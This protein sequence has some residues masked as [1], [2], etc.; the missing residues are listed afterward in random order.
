MANPILSNGQGSPQSLY[1]EYKVTLAGGNQN[2]AEGHH[3]VGTR[4]YLDDG[5]V[6]YYASNGAAA[7]TAGELVSVPATT[8]L[9]VVAS[10]NDIILT[11]TVAAAPW[12]IG[13]TR[14]ALYEADI[15]TA[16]IITNRYKD[17]YLYMEDGTG[18]GFCYKIRGHTQFTYDG[19]A[20]TG[21]IDLYDPIKVAPAATSA[22]SFAVNPYDR[23]VVSAAATYP[24]GVSPTTVTASTALAT[25]TATT[26]A[27]T[28]TYFCWLQTWGPCAV[29]VDDTSVA[30][31][32]AVVAGDTAKEVILANLGHSTGTGTSVTFTGYEEPQIGVGLVSAAQ[33]ASD[34]VLIDLRIR[35]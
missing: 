6:F 22:I 23:V 26:A 16:D 18:E 29:Q 8:G 5:R 7:L 19:T 10:D 2:R 1:D 14:V 15:E 20:T 9:N 33:A 27:S 30:S 13:D 11:S 17:G 31:G 12:A 35:P 3:P 32:D 21:Y 4:G 28:D 25:D 24:V 34:F